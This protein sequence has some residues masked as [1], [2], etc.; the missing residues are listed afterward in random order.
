MFVF[1]SVDGYGGEPIKMYHPKFYHVHQKK[2]IFISTG[3]GPGGIN[4]ANKTKPTIR[5]SI[6]LKLLKQEIEDLRRVYKNNESEIPKDV[7]E[8]LKRKISKVIEQMKSQ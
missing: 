1:L 3:Y 7:M 4:S 6:A 5:N 2:S 8:T